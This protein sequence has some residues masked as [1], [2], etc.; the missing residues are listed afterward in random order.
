M[1]PKFCT[2]RG[3][4]LGLT[5]TFARLTP[6]M[7]LLTRRHYLRSSPVGMGFHTAHTARAS[8]GLIPLR[9]SQRWTNACCTP[10]WARIRARF[11][12]ISTI[13][14]TSE[15]TGVSAHVVSKERSCENASHSDASILTPARSTKGQ[16]KLPPKLTQRLRSRGRCQPSNPPSHLIPAV[17]ALHPASAQETT[18]AFPAALPPTAE[19]SNLV[20]VSPSSSS[21]IMASRRHLHVD[22]H[23]LV[24]S[25]PKTLVLRQI[26]WWFLGACHLGHAEPPIRRGLLQPKPLHLDNMSD[27]ART[28]P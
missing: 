21:L 2:K 11:P 17:G 13:F 18:R 26:V 3:R 8:S 27:A 7:P 10:R 12:R 9:P 25:V 5:V 20:T 4:E 19:S 6:T 16:R 28:T 1:L 23:Q 24:F 14:E 15:V 22:P